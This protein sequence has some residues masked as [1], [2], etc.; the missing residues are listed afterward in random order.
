MFEEF[1]F[2]KISSALAS[3]NQSMREEE[4]AKRQREI[5]ENIAPIKNP[6][7]EL[8]QTIIE[9]NKKQSQKLQEQIDLLKEENEQQKHRLIEAE[10]SEAKAQRAA[11][12]SK[13]FGVISFC[14]S[15]MIAI[16]SLIVAI[17]K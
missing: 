8:L 5:I 14:V 7:V 6:M 3:M 13:I 9:E 12:K 1:D 10:K 11:R 17:V 2:S 4:N 16:A 15:T